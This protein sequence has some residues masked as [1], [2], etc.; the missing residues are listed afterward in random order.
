MLAWREAARV[1]AQEISDAMDKM[2]SA[3]KAG[4]LTTMGIACQ[5][6]HDAVEQFQQHMPS[7]DPELN[8]PLQ[9]A[10][11]DYDAAAR[12]CTTAVENHNI[13]DF[14]QGGTLLQEGN[15]YMDNALQILHRDLGES[16]N[17]STLPS[18]S[19]SSTS[20]P[21]PSPDPVSQLRG[22]A[23]GDRS[24]VSTS[25]AGYWV[26]Q[27][28]SKQPGTYDDGKY[29]DNASILQ[30]HLALRERYGAKLLWSG[31]W[32]GT[33]SDPDYWVTVAP[34]KFADSLAAT[35][36]CRNQGFDSDHCFAKQIH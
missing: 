29:W 17:A 11:S 22:I 14:E 31:D 1:P 18:A 8:A 30:E 5:E 24:F 27:L 28:S 9:K 7:P 23:N 6:A 15:T 3:A 36:W 12:I 33:Y 4:D 2:S 35:T 13:D 34:Q 26:P 25:L 10:L 20:P 19:P 21:P 16:S 32:P